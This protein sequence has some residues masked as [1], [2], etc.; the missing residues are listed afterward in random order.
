L[1]H[2]SLPF[3][4][5]TPEETVAKWAKA[6]SLSIL[7]QLRHGVRY[8]DLRITYQAKEDCF[9]TCHTLISEKVESVLA[10]VL[11]FLGKCQKEIVILDFNHFYGM[12][13]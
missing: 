10:E 13:V 2:L 5:N 9:Y 4:A 1:Q 11:S 12:G 6:Q 7:D 3:F 8:L